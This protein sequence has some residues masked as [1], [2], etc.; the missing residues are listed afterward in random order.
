MSFGKR[1]KLASNEHASTERRVSMRT[2]GCVRYWLFDGQLGQ[3]RKD[4]PIFLLG[5]GT[6]GFRRHIPCV[7]SRPIEDAHEYY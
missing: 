5:K 3:C 4:L 1:L 7:A 2:G 6:H